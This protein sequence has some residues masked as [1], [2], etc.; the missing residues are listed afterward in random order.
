M[1]LLLRFLRWCYRV[2]F[3]GPGLRFIETINAIHNQPKIRPIVPGG[4][5]C[6]EVEMVWN[7]YQH[8]SIQTE[9]GNFQES[10][11]C[12]RSA[13]DCREV[14][15]A[16]GYIGLPRLYAIY[17]GLGNSYNGLGLQAESEEYYKRSL[18]LKPDSEDFSNYEINICGSLWAQGQPR[19][20][21]ASKRLEDF[22]RRRTQMY[23]EEDTVNYL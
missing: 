11:N 8:G 19:L 2:N 5:E 10:Y 18:K 9:L 6:L 3:F 4:A 7:H 20:A 14:A 15:A 23:G 1:K 17:G 16:K 22:I 12:F 21:E 13:L